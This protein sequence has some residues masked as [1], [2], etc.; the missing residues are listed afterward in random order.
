MTKFERGYD[1]PSTKTLHDD[2]I[3]T[4][5]TNDTARQPHAP[6]IDLRVLPPAYKRVPQ[7][8]QNN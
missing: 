2:D 5:R 3:V 8:F 6:S 7:N 4:V 1:E